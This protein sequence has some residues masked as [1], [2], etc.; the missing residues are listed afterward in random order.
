M[1]DHTRRRRA[2][3]G[4]APAALAIILALGTGSPVQAEK[5]QWTVELGPMFT[6]AYGHDQHVLTIHEIDRSTTPQLDRKTAVR[7]DTDDSFAYRG[8]LQYTRERWGVGVDF[9]WFVTT[10]GVASRTAAAGGALDEV[11]FEVADRR[12]V[13]ADPRQ[14]LFYDLLADTDLEAWTVDLYG[15]RTLANGP[16]SAIRLQLGLKLGDFDNDYHAAVG[17]QGV[18][19]SRLDASSNYDRLMGPLVGLSGDYR[20]GR[21]TV[22]GAIGQS[23]L[24]GK[25]E[26]LTSTTGDFTG[27]FSDTPS[28][29]A[30]ETFRAEQDVAI[31]I[32]ESRIKWTYRLTKRISLGAGAD[33]AAWWD[34]PVP[35]GVVPIADGDEALHKSTIVFLGLLGTV[36]VTF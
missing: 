4:A 2:A 31:P 29:F 3:A 19:G 16:A 22:V 12:F 18:G 36:K 5:G 7:L 23:V 9:F 13:S 15:L 20:R 25:V 27:P 32:T 11:V 35:P 1:R 17:V 21:H 30:G 8:E 24:I 28:F 34:V 14:V 26:K 33:A 10:Q 6:E